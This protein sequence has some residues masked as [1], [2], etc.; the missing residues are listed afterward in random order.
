M[1]PTTDNATLVVGYVFT[2]V[3]W[4]MVI[5]LFASSTGNNILRVAGSL[6]A[7]ACLGGCLYLHWDPYVA[8]VC[9]P[10]GFIAGVLYAEWHYGVHRLTAPRSVQER[11]RQ[12]ADHMERF[13]QESRVMLDYERGGQAYRIDPDPGSRG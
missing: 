2:I 1:S 6:F 10:A 11:Q 13:Q 7:L 3:F 8:M 9:L 4:A 12:P 5:W